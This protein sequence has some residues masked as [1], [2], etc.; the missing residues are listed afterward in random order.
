MGD[1]QKKEEPKPLSADEVKVI[2]AGLLPKVG[3]DQS[4]LNEALVR[5]NRKLRDDLTAAQSTALPKDHVAVPKSDADLLVEYRALGE[6]KAL[7][8]AAEEAPA[9]KAT[10]AQRDHDAAL[11]TVAAKAGYAPEVLRRLAPIGT[12]FEPTKAKDAK[13][14]EV[15][16]FTV[17][18]KGPDG[19]DRTR[20]LQQWEDDPEV[21]PLLPA[22]KPS[23]KAPTAADGV[24]I[25]SSS[26]IP[27]RKPR[28]RTAREDERERDDPRRHVGASS[29]GRL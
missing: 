18:D 24:P 2:V 20:S 22:L 27:D 1:E 17:K 6:P 12:A 19:K 14:K 21:K 28:E 8:A 3:G 25:S 26:G 29:Y 16:S 9:L 5:Q 11:A 10:L 7:K 4:K 13:G 23:G 15:E